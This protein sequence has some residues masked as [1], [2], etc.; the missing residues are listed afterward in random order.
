MSRF[1]CITSAVYAGLDSNYLSHVRNPQNPVA[2]NFQTAQAKIEYCTFMAKRDNMPLTLRIPMTLYSLS[3][4]LLNADGTR[5]RAE[6]ARIGRKD[7]R[8]TN[9]NFLNSPLFFFFFFFF[10]YCQQNEDQNDWKFSLIC[11]F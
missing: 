8:E 6:H 7:E 5:N 4:S 9:R 3:V 2:I 1:H 10:S 11:H